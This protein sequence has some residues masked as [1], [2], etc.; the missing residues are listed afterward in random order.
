MSANGSRVR[1]LSG[2]DSLF[3]SM[4]RP[5]WSQSIAA[6]VVLDG[7]APGFAGYSAVRSLVAQRLAVIPRLRWKLKQTPLGLAR[8]VWVADPQFA[9][10]R[11]LRRVTVPAPG[12]RRE[13]GAAVA[14]VMAEP[15]DRRR[16]LWELVYVDGLA[17]GAAAVIAK[18]HH[19]VMDGRG[20]ADLMTTLFDSEP[21]GSAGPA[22]GVWD[23]P[24]EP[25]SFE[26]F[27]RGVGSSLAT[28]P[29]AARYL[30]RLAERV[31]PALAAFRDRDAAPAVVPRSPF[32]GA[33]GPHRGFAVASIAFADVIRAKS[34]LGT[35][36]NDIV[37]ATVAGAARGY[38]QSQATLPAQ[39]LVAAVPLST[40]KAN[41]DGSLNDVVN[42][43]V[44]LP[45]DE[46][47]PL[48]RVRRTSRATK[49]A[50]A[51]TAEVRRTPIESIGVVLPPFVVQGAAR[52]IDA[53]GVGRLGPV[54]GG[55][56]LV[57]SI[58]GPI[59][60]RY[61]AGARVLAVY[62]ASIV[63]V[64][65][66]LNITLTSYADRVDFGVAVDSDLVPDPWL[67]AD[68]LP[69]AFAELMHAAGLGAVEAVMDPLAVNPRGAP[70]G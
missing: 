52:L 47:S 4:E 3:V 30:F 16:P 33:V 67:L 12:E 41:A 61:A 2:T 50:K 6:V 55:D 20:L 40:A 27:A 29:R 59:Q 8:P 28:G 19:S 63:M 53:T 17:S 22:V 35:T 51:F 56:F 65:M 18:F 9:V 13:L 43:W 70:V 15:L 44:T 10:D 21:Q 45:T 60:P 34:V 68:E 38:L 42:T 37:L 69:A 58:R 57:S 49:V 5:A 66:G 54:A 23:D 26:L 62:P 7:N 64:N 32:N 14:T 11:Q 24:R 1:R 48:E 36:F 46:A 25:S 39:P 31:P